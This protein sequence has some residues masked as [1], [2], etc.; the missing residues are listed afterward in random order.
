[1]NNQI[2]ILL[3]NQENVV[4]FVKTANA[5]PCDIDIKS[6]KYISVLDAKSILGVMSMD[7]NNPLIAELNTEDQETIDAFKQDIQKYIVE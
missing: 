4:E 2:K 5:C 6:I 7:I 3:G 1:M